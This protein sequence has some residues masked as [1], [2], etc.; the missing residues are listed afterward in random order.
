MKRWIAPTALLL[1][2][3]GSP[4]P[5]PVVPQTP[6]TP[7]GP[8]AE[9]PKGTT[10]PADPF[11]LPSNLR[12]DAARPPV[13][14][15]A[16]DALVDLRALESIPPAPAKC[17]AYAKR[18]ADGAAC[19]DGKPPI[20]RALD[21]ALEKKDD[22]ARDGALVAA[23]ACR[24]DGL[25]TALRAELAPPECADAIVEPWLA[26]HTPAGAAGHALVGLAVS[27]KL[28]R[29]AERP[30][31]FTG[32][33]DRAAIKKFLA[34]PFGAWITEQAR[35]IEALSLIAS[36]LSGYGRGIAAVEAGVADMRLVEVARA[37]EIPDA[38]K[39]DEEI[40]SVYY[41]A[42]DAAL[43]PRKVR[44][45]SAALAG[46]QELA[47]EGVA[48]SGRV[49]RAHALL[50][51]MFAGRRI[52]ALRALHLP[53]APR[54]DCEPGSPMCASEDGGYTT[55]SSVPTF[56]A[57]QLLGDAVV[58]H[59]L[60]YL[61]LLQG[62]PPAYVRAFSNEAK[63]PADPRTR[64][65][66][67]RARLA[68]GL[69]TWRGVD[70]D[71]AALWASKV[72]DKAAES[73]KAKAI[74]ALALALGRGPDGAA[75]MMASRSRCAGGDWGADGA[76]CGPAPELELMHVDALDAL[77]KTATDARTRAD[78][79]FN[80][81]LLLWISTPPCCGAT[82]AKYFGGVAE[83]FGRAAAAFGGGSAA[84]KARAEAMLYRAQAEEL[85]RIFAR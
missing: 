62:A 82:T 34:G 37:A 38:W 75:A 32:A 84:E 71:Q 46:L 42:L 17:A 30:P 15:T 26:K 61:P 55:L 45:R 65:A 36:K 73:E 48:E 79:D 5:Q 12:A 80:A 6:D 21:S 31:R 78:A 72:G 39:A 70:F 33:K 56:Y 53:D 20:Y 3:C 67:A 66:Y 27:G 81:A 51:K 35:A 47:L 50:G 52:D 44:G 24:S 59:P 22:A 40:R 41:A 28:A 60:A 77:A 76:K 58:G 7:P 83:R 25:I 16:A 63:A 14:D 29:T 64:F 43:E 13:P 68:L 4:P 10:A 1:F 74:V 57:E 85:S 11:A 19:R 18:K 69:V 23:E 2:A 9:T 49:T 8:G 54:G